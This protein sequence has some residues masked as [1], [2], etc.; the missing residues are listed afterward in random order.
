MDR[1]L[2]ADSELELAKVDPGSTPGWKKGK[3]AGVKAL[4]KDSI[5]L[6]V[7]QEKLF[8]QSVAGG[9]R[10]LLVVL[11][12]MDTAGKGGIVRH[13]FRAADPAG[14]VSHAFKAP[15]E[16]EKQHD[17]LWRVRPHLPPAGYLGIFD[18]SHYEDVL[19]ARV[20]HLASPEEIEQ[21][22]GLINEFE[23]ELVASGTEVVKIMLHISPEEQ[24]SRLLARLD[25]PD[26]Q[27]K[28]SP[29]DLDDR[30]LWPDYQEAYQIAIRRTA[31]EAAPWFVVPADHKW[32][33]RLAVQTIALAK[34]REF[35]NVWP[36]PTYD[37]QAERRRLEAD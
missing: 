12:A 5:D 3:A 35:N 18:R 26:K 2:R 15:T 34:L 23:A 1:L 25:T 22:Y 20:R 17:F 13:A 11:Q 37:V 6:G 32:Y 4:A 28:Y 10:S 30:E 29:G 9:T 24:K 16:E 14:L 19:V 7:L 33:A 27:W 31:T 36:S 21:R 8:A